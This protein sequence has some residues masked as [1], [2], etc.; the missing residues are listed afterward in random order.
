MILPVGSTIESVTYFVHDSSASY[1]LSLALVGITQPA[2]STA[3]QSTTSTVG[4]SGD[5]TVTQTVGHVVVPDTAYFVRA[6]TLYWGNAG[7]QSGYLRGPAGADFDLFLWYWNGSA[8]V[9][10]ASGETASTNESIV[11][12]GA[13]G[14]YLWGVYSYSGT[15]TYHFYYDHP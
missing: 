10:V 1:S 4:V 3:L 7:N 13:A 6:S 11:Y 12:N 9:E 5:A 8:W 14:W 15:G 2:K